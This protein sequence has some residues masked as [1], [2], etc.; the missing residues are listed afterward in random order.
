MMSPMTQPLPQ[1]VAERNTLAR[2]TDPPLIVVIETLMA[3]GA[4]PM[5]IGRPIDL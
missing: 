3:I 2:S 5:A 4:M 1:C